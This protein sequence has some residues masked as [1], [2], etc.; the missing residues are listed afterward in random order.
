[1]H[2]STGLFYGISATV[3]PL[4]K[5]LRDSHHSYALLIYT[6]IYSSCQLSSFLAKKQSSPAC[7]SHYIIQY[8]KLDSR[9]QHLFFKHK[10]STTATTIA[11]TH[12]FFPPQKAFWNNFCKHE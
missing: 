1:M 9:N 2:L 4:Q 3:T 11:S 5:A 7:F 10:N 8:K 6:I 12:I